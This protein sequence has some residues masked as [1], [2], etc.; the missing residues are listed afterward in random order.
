MSG[1]RGA[2]GGGRGGRRS[3]SST[4]VLGG[5]EGSGSGSA[6]RSR[7]PQGQEQEEMNAVGLACDTC[8]C[9]LASWGCA[10]SG[11][12]G[13]VLKL[14]PFLFAVGQFMFCSQISEAHLVAACCASFACFPKM[15]NAP[16]R[17]SMI[18]DI[19]GLMPWR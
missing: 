3:S 12:G 6:S 5:Q 17:T 15:K 16:S 2:R 18:I 7:Q 11:S 19:G 4:P 1:G 10:F 14:R 13:V 9:V 8:T